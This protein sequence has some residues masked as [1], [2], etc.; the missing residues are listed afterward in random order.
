MFWEHA[1]Y[2]KKSNLVQRDIISL[3]NVQPQS[4]AP[5]SLE[6]EPINTSMKLK[7]P[8]MMQS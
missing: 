5:L 7:D 4:P 2:L 8:L 1:V 3:L 6:V